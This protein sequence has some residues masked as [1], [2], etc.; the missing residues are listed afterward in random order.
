MD[1]LGP[2][3]FYIILSYAGVGLLTAALIIGTFWRARAEQARL[4][5]LEAQGHRRRSAKKSA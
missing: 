2:H 3:S 4:D 1:G 5:K